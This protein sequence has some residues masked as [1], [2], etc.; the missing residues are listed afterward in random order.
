[1]ALFD[2]CRNCP[3]PQWT[4]GKLYPLQLFCFRWSVGNIFRIG[5]PRCR[6]AAT[7]GRTECRKLEKT[8]RRFTAESISNRSLPL[9]TSESLE[10]SRNCTLV[11]RFRSLWVL[12]NYSTTSPDT[13][14]C[15]AV[16][17]ICDWGCTSY[18]ARFSTMPKRWGRNG[19]AHGLYRDSSRHCII[20]FLKNYRECRNYSM[21]CEN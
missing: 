17:A 15:E 9:H 3:M 10:T 8:F 7:F 16:Q 2:F 4:I 20:W 11:Y 21:M 12:R 6:R 1:M 5:P 18:T 13:Y 14:T 19:L